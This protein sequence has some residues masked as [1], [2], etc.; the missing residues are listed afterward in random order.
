MDFGKMFQKGGMG[1]LTSLIS[2][3]A[4]IVIANPS[5]ITNLI[6]A[7]WGQMT[8]SALVGFIIVAA[9]NWWK[10][11]NVPAGEPQK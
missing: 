8:L 7:K 1:F 4:G 10:N 11:K 3:G 9:A 6:P 2:A 5:L